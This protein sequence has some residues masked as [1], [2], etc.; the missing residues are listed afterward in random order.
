MKRVMAFEEAI[1][2]PA[3]AWILDE[4][5]DHP[6]YDLPLPDVGFR[7]LPEVIHSVVEQD[8]QGISPS[9]AGDARDGF[10]GKPKTEDAVK[11]IL[12]PAFC[13]SGFKRRFG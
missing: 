5:A 7:K 12:C 8:F 1:A 2:E 4:K 3:Q 9:G 11:Q 6:G 13:N 10:L